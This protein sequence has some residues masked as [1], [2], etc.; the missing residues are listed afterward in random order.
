M[1]SLT[2]IE[3]GDPPTRRKSCLACTKSRRRCDQG[4]PACQRCSQRNIDCRY[5][6]GARPGPPPHR[7]QEEQVEPE[8]PAAFDRTDTPDTSCLRMLDFM[9]EPAD[10]F[11]DQLFPAPAQFDAPTPSLGSGLSP[12]G[13][14][15]LTT[16]QDALDRSRVI[17]VPQVTR[18]ISSRLQY[19]ID[20]IS[21][22]PCQMVLEN[23]MPWCHAHLYD[24]GMPR[25]M[26]Y[27]VSSAALHAAKNSVNARVIRDNME[28]RVQDLLSSPA[29]TTPLETLAYAQALF[30][31]QVL[32]L[33]D[34]DARVRS[35][36]E[37]TMPHLEE[38]AFALIPHISFDETSSIEEPNQAPETLPLYPVSAAREFW[39]S[40]VF[41]ESARRT[42]NL[43]SFFMLTYRYM[44]GEAGNHCERNASVC[45][46]V[47]ISARLWSARDP[48]DFA[49]AWK[50]K[51]HFVVHVDSLNE[52]T[53]IMD[54]A[55]SDDIDDFG[56]I[57]LTALMG[58]DEAK[59]WLAMRGITL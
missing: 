50:N 41:Q 6:Q 22:A 18:A 47:T 15:L 9:L 19:A 23:Q 8:L 34:S 30:M 27:A 49:L 11:T 57:C 56:K 3:R 2:S 1:R 40:W 29:T 44:K 51:K 33:L 55:R 39:A 17:S 13:P 53:T 21:A 58:L 5:P 32:R 10:G 7:L 42:L 24:D 38:A 46:S 25:C 52:M 16:A 45:R 31:Y 20:K 35:N 36:Y 54:D 4:R 14:R 59:G 12:F 37:A 26:Q 43:I 48:I 28:S